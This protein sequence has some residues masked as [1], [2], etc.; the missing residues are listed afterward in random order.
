MRRATE[1]RLER[2]LDAGG[3]G[4]FEH[5]PG[6]DGVRLDGRALALTGIAAEPDGEVRIE[7][8]LRH[9]HPEDRARVLDD[10]AL[11]PPGRMHGRTHY[12]VVRPD[13]ALRHVEAAAH[14][15][16]GENGQPAAAFGMVMDVTER[17]QGEAER[18]RLVLRLGERVK[19]LHLLH[20][21][22]HLLQHASG[23]DRLLLTELVARMPAA[24]LHA[25]DA[26]ARIAYGDLEAV[27]PGWSTT[28]W[29]QTAGF[30]TSNGPGVLQVAYQH[31]HPAAEEGPFLVEER[32]LID[33]LAEMLRSHVERYVVEQR[34]QAVEEQLRQAQKMDALGTLAGGVAHDFNN[35]LT[36]IHGYGELA[37]LE[38]RP[39]G[40]Q[41]ES[42]D[43]ILKACVRARD[44][45]RRI[46]L[47]SRGQQSSR[48]VMP[49][50]PV[51]EEALQLLRAT[52]PRSIEIRSHATPHPP[53]VRA[54]ATQMHQ[55]MMNLGTNA[56]YAMREQGGVLSV[57]L[58]V[59]DVET[60]AAG[61][62]AELKPGRYLRLT[63]TDTGC[64]M[65]PEIR[66][67]LFEPFFTTKGHA[68]TGL[69][70]SVVHGIVRDHGG[71]ISVTSEPGEG[72]RFDIHLPAA[73]EAARQQADNPAPMPRGAGQHIMYVDDE[74]AL[75][76]I[77]TRILA[78]LGYRCT[79]FTDPV[80]ALQEFRTAPHDF[81]AV[82]TDLQMPAMSGLD[83]ARAVRSVRPGVPVAIASGL[84]PDHIA[85]D[86]DV[87][88]VAWPQHRRP[89]RFA[90]PPGA[91]RGSALTRQ[92]SILPTPS[93]SAPMIRIAT[94]GR[95]TD[96]LHLHPMI[97]IIPA[98]LQEHTYGRDG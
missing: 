24:W 34:R 80:A 43:E 82:V 39:G 92:S 86:P 55:V 67:R 25:G 9:V 49:L 48:D 96:R 62:A 64:G 32:A 66:E 75:C 16:E 84:P 44:L 8:W 74:P 51:V 54:D 63:V 20:E 41:R 69:G 65:R 22:A 91:R 52:L 53:P 60:A 57:E 19:E 27:S 79:A 42:I 81:D 28:P 13:G 72:S 31:E 26:R 93:W 85:T 97:L 58:G 35:I 59:I 40:E 88:S 12:R 56:A 71:S 14:L 18:E 1:L 17:K 78:H 47:F 83:L 61:F 21:A 87:E 23:V 89:S 45:V 5:V 6:S 4:I 46:L 10:L 7:A 3:I 70:L 73:P 33:S 36:A 77:M 68:G 95:M 29:M 2:A 15:V 38:A 30:S 90:A 37:L 94:A 11:S 76:H 50:G 98:D